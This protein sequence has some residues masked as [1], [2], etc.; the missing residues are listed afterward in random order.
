MKF[1]PEGSR[2]VSALPLSSRKPPAA[3]SQE[4]RSTIHRHPSI[5]TTFHCA[6]QNKSQSAGGCPP[7]YRRGALFPLHSP[8]VVLL[9]WHPTSRR[10]CASDRRV[11]FL[12]ECSETRLTQAG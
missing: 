10:H 12:Q 2:G 9:T 5:Q 11:T 6:S 7:T 8:A 4:L 1:L 3:G